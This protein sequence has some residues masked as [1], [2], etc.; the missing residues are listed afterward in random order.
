M[1]VDTEQLD[2]LAAILKASS[3][4]LIAPGYHYDMMHDVERNEAYA[5][6]LAAAVVPEDFVLD[7]GAGSSLL[8]LLATQTSAQHIF[9]CEADR[10]LAAAARAVVQANEQEARITVISK[11]ST[12][13]VVGWGDDLPCRADVLVTE[14]FDS[15]LIG[16]GLLATMA[17]ARARLVAPD[18]RSVPH[19]AELVGMLLESAHVRAMACL[20]DDGPLLNPLPASA[21]A[22]AAHGGWSPE[23]IHLHVE[24]LIASGLA[25]PLSAGFETMR[26]ELLGAPPPLRRQLSVRVTADGVC[27]AVL[28]WFRLQAR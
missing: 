28:V 1:H 24:P 21:T 11:P 13:L 26:F 9:A 20:R 15:V 22:A 18:A 12:R 19:A 8:S 6:A 10:P 17:D 16:E 5:E 2:Q 27:H 14:I 3:S 4:D 25:R 7:I 23:A